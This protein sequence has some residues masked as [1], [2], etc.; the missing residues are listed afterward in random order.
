MSKS[1]DEKIKKQINGKIGK[2]DGKNKIV[3]KL[4]KKNGGAKERSQTKKK[5]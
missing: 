1:I 2:G 4:K 3:G 5:R